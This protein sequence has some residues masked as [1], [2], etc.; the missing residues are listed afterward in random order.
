MID[1][2]P[3]TRLNIRSS[4]RG[5]C[6]GI[7]L[8]KFFIFLP[9]HLSPTNLLFIPIVSSVVSVPSRFSSVSSAVPVITLHPPFFSQ[10]V[11]LW[12]FLPPPHAGLSS[13]VSNQCLL[14]YQYLAS[15]IFFFIIAIFFIAI[16]I[17]FSSYLLSSSFLFRIPPPFPP[18][19]FSLHIFFELIPLTSISIPFLPSFLFCVRCVCVCVIQTCIFVCSYLSAYD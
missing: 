18:H 15:M 3:L 8:S 6:T 2:S 19:I 4:H 16:F 13:S 9:T 10:T 17:S 11:L 7:N 1:S 5:M 14:H 12:M